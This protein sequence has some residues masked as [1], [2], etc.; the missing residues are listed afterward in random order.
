[1][2][3]SSPRHAPNWRQTISVADTTHVPQIL[4]HRHGRLTAPV[5]NLESDGLEFQGFFPSGR[6]TSP[7]TVNAPAPAGCHTPER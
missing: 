2:L 4:S 7:H 5:A 6:R 3:G 1:M